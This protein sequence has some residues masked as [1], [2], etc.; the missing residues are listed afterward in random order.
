MRGYAH[1]PDATAESIDGDGLFL[2]LRRR[3]DPHGDGYLSIVDRTKD[4]LLYKG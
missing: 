2:T 4:M 1:R 3:G